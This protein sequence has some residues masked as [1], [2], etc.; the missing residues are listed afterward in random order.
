MFDTPGQTAFT[1]LQTLTD[2]EIDEVSG[3]IFFLIPVIALIAAAAVGYMTAK[4]T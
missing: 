1:G 4:A 2:T 3:G